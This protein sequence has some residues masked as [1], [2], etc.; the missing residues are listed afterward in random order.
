M[1]TS[2]SN[3]NASLVDRLCQP[4]TVA[5]IGKQGDGLAQAVQ[6][7]VESLVEVELSVRD[8]TAGVVQR[9]MQ[10]SWTASRW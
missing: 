5:I 10:E 3:L 4:V 7:G 1:G 9:G 2:G 8:E 6:K